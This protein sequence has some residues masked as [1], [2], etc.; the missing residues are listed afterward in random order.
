MESWRVEIQNA[1]QHTERQVQRLM[2][3]ESVHNDLPLPQWIKDKHGRMLAL[4]KSYVNVFLA[5][6]G[7]DADDYIGKTDEDVW[8]KDIGSKYMLHDEW[9]MEK[10][11]PI[12]LEEVVKTTD[13]NVLWQIF[14][15]PRFEDG[16]VVG[17][18]G[19]AYKK[20]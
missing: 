1:L 19:L 12:Y 2:L 6:L 5:A 17:V 11:Q 10:K 13:G 4:N 7:K 14:K 18:G 15:Y 16:V 8:G 20:I 9:V 3:L